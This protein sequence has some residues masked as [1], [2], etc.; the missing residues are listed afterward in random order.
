VPSEEELIETPLE[1]KTEQNIGGEHVHQLRI[2]QATGR[3]S[4]EGVD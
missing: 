2:S 1:E 3:P 4:N